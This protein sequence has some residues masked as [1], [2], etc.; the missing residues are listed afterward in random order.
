MGLAGVELVEPQFWPL[1]RDHGLQIVAITGHPLTPEGLNKRENLAVLER[2]I[3]ERLELAVKWN[4]P[5]LLCFSG[6]RYGVDEET[7]AKITAENLS[8]VAQ[9]FKGTDVTLLLEL[10]NSK[11]NNRDYQADHSA[12]AIKVCEMV[13][14]PSVRLLYDIFHMQIMEGDI[15]QTIR[16]GRRYFAHYHTAGNPGRAEI[17]QSQELNYLPIVKAIVEAGYQGYIGHE[18]IPKGDPISAL[19]YAF[20]LCVKAA[21]T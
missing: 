14:S 9:W 20:D 6:N 15:I 13:D 12:W 11:A 16:Q 17:D 7:A 18:F 4:I 3:Y 10:L 2:Q 5:F 1:I 19:K 8:H 21:Q